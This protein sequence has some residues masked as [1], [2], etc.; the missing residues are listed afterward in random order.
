MGQGLSG[1]PLFTVDNPCDQFSLGAVQNFIKYLLIS[2]WLLYLIKY[3]KKSYSHLHID[4]TPQWYQ[5]TSK[6]SLFKHKVG[7]V[8]VCV[9]SYMYV[10]FLSNYKASHHFLLANLRSIQYQLNLCFSKKELLYAARQQG[11]GWISEH[12]LRELAF[13]NCSCQKEL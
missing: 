13:S 11:L 9:R 4:N 3:T 6:I 1:C 5:M 12:P 10:C 7:L 2:A 8:C